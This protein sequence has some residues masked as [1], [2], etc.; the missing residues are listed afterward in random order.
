HRA[1]GRSFPAG[2]GEF[3]IRLAYCQAAGQDANDRPYGSIVSLNEHGAVLYYMDRDR[4]PPSPVRSF[5]IDAGASHDGYACDITRTYSA[6]SGD[7]FQAL[8][9]A[10]DA[11]QLRMCAQVRAGFDYRQ[12]HLDA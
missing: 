1:G 12:L 8:V 9:D 11:A 7:E 10:V 4:L 6:N 5:L 2:V 3:G